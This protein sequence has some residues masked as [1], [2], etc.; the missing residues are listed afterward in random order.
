[1]DS[2]LFFFLNKRTARFAYDWW[3][4]LLLFLGRRTLYIRIRTSRHPKTPHCVQSIPD[5]IAKMVVVVKPVIPTFVGIQQL[6]KRENNK[7]ESTIIGWSNFDWGKNVQKLNKRAWRRDDICGAWVTKP[8]HWKCHGINYKLHDA[9]IIGWS[10]CI[11]V[12]YDG[13]T[14]VNFP[15]P[16]HN[17]V[18]L[19]FA[20]HLNNKKYFAKEIDRAHERKKFTRIFVTGNEH[21]VPIV[22]S[23]S[24]CMLSGIDNAPFNRYAHQTRVVYGLPTKE[25]ATTD[26]VM[27]LRSEDD[28]KSLARHQIQS[29]VVVD[30]FLRHRTHD[31][32][33]EGFHCGDINWISTFS[34]KNVLSR[35]IVYVKNNHRKL[36]LTAWILLLKSGS[37][38][39]ALLASWLVMIMSLGSLSR[40]CGQVMRRSSIHLM[41][42]SSHTGFPQHTVGGADC[43]SKHTKHSPS[44]G[45][46]LLFILCIGGGMVTRWRLSAEEEGAV[47]LFVA[48]LVVVEEEGAVLVATVVVEEEGAVLV[49]TV[50]VDVEDS[51]CIGSPNSLVRRLLDLR[52]LDSKL[53]EN[54]LLL[55]GIFRKKTLETNLKKQ[56][57]RSSDL[58]DASNENAASAFLLYTCP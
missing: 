20:Q 46:G 3:F 13:V 6:K 14:L 30:C 32:V 9:F 28:G 25:H 39:S 49:A 54:F 58:D 2:S 51:L 26:L 17:N 10:S 38:K 37:S 15:Y 45:R 36:R 23:S 56:H 41:R 22:Q 48:V 27:K 21:T 4:A 11:Q 52:L 24:R 31:N 12:S 34:K 33:L 7:Q 50:V 40:Q 42:Q 19:R 29:W 18:P 5:F 35:K 44:I 53:V 1:M 55:L 57:S 43:P 8:F 47:S 16:W